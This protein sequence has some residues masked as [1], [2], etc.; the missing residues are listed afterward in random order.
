MDFNRRKDLHDR[1][2]DDICVYLQTHG[3]RAVSSTYHDR[4]EKIAQESI[5]LK[6]DPTS[7]YVRFRADNTAVPVEDTLP[8]FQWD[9]KTNLS[10]EHPNMALEVIPLM[11]HK[12]L[13][14]Q[15]GVRCLYCY[16]D[17]IRDRHAG[18]WINNLPFVQCVLVPRNWSGHKA[19]TWLESLIAVHFPFVPVTYIDS[20]LGSGTPYVLISFEHVKELPDWK[21]LIRWAGFSLS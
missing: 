3:Y 11:F 5:K 12:V 7:L 14:S 21:E 8:S 17:C 15:F 16:Y 4:W 9:A 19:S 20:T 13:W 1:F 6:Y 18:F 2:Y 10:P